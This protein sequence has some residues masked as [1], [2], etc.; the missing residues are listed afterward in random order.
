MK[1]YFRGALLGCGALVL[2]GCTPDWATSNNTPYILEIASITADGGTLPILSDVSVGGSVFND[3]AEVIISL[4]RKNNSD[5]LTTSPV[6][7]V[8]LERYEVRYFRTDGRNTEG[9]DV[10]FRTTGPLSNLRFLAV[11]PGDVAEIEASI[12]IVRHQAKLEPPLRNLKDVFLGDTRTVL[13]GGPGIMTA[14]AEITV[15][16]RTVQGGVLSAV[17]R[18]NVTFADFADTGN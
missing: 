18:V 9:V 16:G 4:F 3:E 7:N 17:G 10:P 8:T 2:A 11:D 12:T 14:V 6:Q 15:H 13:F 5:G 1:A